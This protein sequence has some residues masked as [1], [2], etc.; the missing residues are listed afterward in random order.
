MDTEYGIQYNKYKLGEN[1]YL[2]IP[3]NI[4]EGMYEDGE[5]YSKRKK[6][7]KVCNSIENIEESKTLVDDIMDGEDLSYYYE[8]DEDISFLK[9]YYLLEQMDFVVF[10]TIKNGEIFKKRIR[11]SEL[12]D[13]HESEI[14]EMLD[15]EPSVIL[16]DK[17][18]DNLL[19][20]NN[21]KELKKELSSLKNKIGKYKENTNKLISKLVIKDSK[22]S[23]IETNGK[24]F[25]NVND[26]S[27][28]QINEFGEV[29]DGNQYPIINHDISVSGLYNYLRERVIGHEKELKII[30]TKLIRNTKAIEGEKTK[31]ILVPGPTGTG[32]TLTFEVASEYMG[33]PYVFA[34]TADLVPEGIVGT[35]IQDVFLSLINQCNGDLELAKRAI[36][37][38]DEFDKL[39]VS[40]L[41]IKQSVKP[42]FL[43][44]LEGTKL[45]LQEKEGFGYS[46][47]FF[48]TCLLNKVFLGAFS[49]CFKEEKHLG[50]N[51][52]TES[53]KL[54]SKDKMY[55]CGYYDR[56][57]I[58][59]I[60]IVVPYYELTL[61]EMKKTLFC[62][63]SEL[64]KEINALKRDFNIEV[65]GIDEFA[66]GIIE[67]LS[68]KDT[69]MRDLNN[70]I[71]NSFT[72][73]EYELEDNPDK[74]KRLTLNKNT[75]K[76][77]TD[78]D[79]A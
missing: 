61:D 53:S 26:P 42:I 4:I 72:D 54:F 55:E 62:K 58:T 37:V 15:D 1:I 79:L 64:L 27:Y 41:D 50:F 57:L 11:V 36:V 70:L 66:Q 43:K 32:K 65:D 34:N 6:P 23:R 38:F 10:V 3:T 48:D 56:E 60:P 39:E 59:R 77:S 25:I 69:S 74:F 13:K 20:I 45:N 28:K 19:D 5:F 46:N 52:P 67:L 9:D 22:V 31:S 21:L 18:V 78:F 63:S 17:I 35:S 71:I 12:Q 33:L 40:G 51:N 44:I 8:C 29:T 47:Y 7:I 75:V 14:Y 30:A 76:D 24:Y 16:S 2:L 73:I 68:K 49:E